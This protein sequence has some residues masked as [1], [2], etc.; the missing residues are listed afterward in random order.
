MQQ[1]QQENKQ[2][3]NEPSG[4]FINIC[5]RKREKI[6]DASHLNPIS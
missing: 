5:I 2:M 6:N 1:Q 4:L 3:Q